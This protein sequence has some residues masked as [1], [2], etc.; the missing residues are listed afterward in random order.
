MSTPSAT[1]T[2]APIPYRDATPTGGPSIVGALTT[3]LLLL[4]AVA[5]L[6]LFARKR[7]WLDRWI[8]QAPKT[9]RRV[10]VLE[11]LPL[12]RHTRLFR[13]RDGERVYLLSESTA[14]VDVLD[15]A[16]ATEISP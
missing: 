7:G 5:A 16:A 3:T 6:A 9:T 11:S 12:S 8:T 10:V 15:S 1:A 2:V 4:A 13:V 14:K